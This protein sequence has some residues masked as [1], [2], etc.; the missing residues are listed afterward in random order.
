[1]PELPEVEI[2]TIALRQKLENHSIKAIDI[3]QPNLRYPLPAH[4]R[5]IC[6][7]QKINSLTRHGKIILWHF[8]NQAILL[9]H[10]GMSGRWKIISPQQSKQYKRVKHDHLTMVLD[11]D[12]HLFYHDPRRFGY[13]DYLD[14]IDSWN[15]HPKL[16]KLGPDALNFD[17]SSDAFHKSLSNKK[18]TI[19]RALL[20]QQIIAGIGNIYAC[21]ILWH[22]AI[23]PLSPCNHLTKPQ[24]DQIIKATQLVL[25]KAIQSGGSSMR[26]FQDPNGKLGYFAHQW[27][28]Y[29]QENQKCT[30]NKCTGIIKKILDSGRS[31]Y[32]C[33]MHQKTM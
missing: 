27:S 11:D 6:L 5:Q 15:K 20:N 3:F 17:L 28:C 14:H 22:S 18:T 1:M 23:H 9:W 29:G 8:A 4:L 2:T 16:F 21:E 24:T 31:T 19:K 33:A 25:K 26:D 12:T 10:L 30:R 7:H 13:C 32:Y